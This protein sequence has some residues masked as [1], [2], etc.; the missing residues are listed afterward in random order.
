MCKAGRV[1]AR[2]ERPTTKDELHQNELETKF[3][4]DFGFS[5]R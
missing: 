5:W 2:E 1:T 3:L 4:Q